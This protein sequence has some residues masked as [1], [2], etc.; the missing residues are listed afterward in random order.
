LGDIAVYSTTDVGNIAVWSLGVVM[1]LGFLGLEDAWK[2]ILA[3]LAVIVVACIL[4]K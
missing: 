1:V 4:Q 2:M 3:L